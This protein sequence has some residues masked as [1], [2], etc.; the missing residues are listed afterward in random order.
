[1]SCIVIALP[2][3][4]MLALLLHNKAS[5]WFWAGASI[6][7]FIVNAGLPIQGIAVPILYPQ[8]LDIVVRISLTVLVLF[9]ITLLTQV[10]E[11]KRAE[12]ERALEAEKASVQRRVEEAVAALLAEQEAARRKDEEILRT[13][14]ELQVYLETSISTILTEMEKFSEGDL[15]VSVH[16][17]ASDNIGR[18]Y[19]GFNHAIGKMRS[20]VG[21]VTAMVEETATTS[22][23]IA[24]RIQGVGER[25][26]I[27]A[28]GTATMASA[29]EEMTQTISE[30]AH[31]TMSVAEEAERA[32]RDAS[33][34]G[35]VVEA[36][37]QAVES[38]AK[39]IGNAAK[40]LQAL[41]QS[42]E[43]IGA[44]TT[45]IDEIADQ[46]NLLALNAAIEAAR[47]GEHGRGF[48]V[49]ADE[50]RK[51]AERTQKATKEIAQTV[52]T[53]Q[54]QSSGAIQEIGMGE[55]EV[56]TGKQT[57]IQARESLRQIM[58]RT[59][60]VSEIIRQI[61]TAEEEQSRAALDIARSIEEIRRITEES[62][63]AM[64]MVLVDVEQMG[65]VTNGLA[66]VVGQF[67]ISAIAESGVTQSR[68]LELA[69]QRR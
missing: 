18:L 63:A 49:V 1:M 14:E 3:P 69:Y 11:T 36:T 67:R 27:Q 24:R 53:I 45:I 31:Q 2:L 52:K 20:L 33:D 40:T 23:G 46:T 22:A 54:V 47:A 17:T 32:E 43:D 60:R 6:I 44:I 42:S 65:D 39:V 25:L 58:E 50:V 10:F 13:S 48:A 12:S 19:G 56:E 34:G 37:M 26:A 68:V 61:A 35:A 16:S 4:S 66:D 51:L 57:A 59:R 21:R 28:T 41:G 8:E 5:G 30:N 15:T 38:I 64:D 9:A 55:A 7:S 62:V 29:I